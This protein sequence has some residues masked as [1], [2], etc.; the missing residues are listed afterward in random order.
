MEGGDIEG[1]HRAG[2]RSRRED[3][4]SSS[5][6]EQSE[7]RVLAA[8]RH[9]EWDSFSDTMNLKI[10]YE[11]VVASAAAEVHVPE[12]L[13]GVVDTDVGDRILM[14]AVRKDYIESVNEI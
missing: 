13:A 4:S 11:A 3:A 9:E 14:R 5:E 8:R 7:N 2:K 1:E 12:T 6:E 10:A